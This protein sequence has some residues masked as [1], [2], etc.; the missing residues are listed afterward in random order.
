[1]RDLTY[2]IR[3]NN[4]LNMMHYLN[5]GEVSNFKCHQ[6]DIPGIITDIMCYNESLAKTCD[7]DFTDS[8]VG[9]Y[10]L[11]EVMTNKDMAEEICGQFSNKVPDK[12][13]IYNGRYGCKEATDHQVTSAKFRC[14]NVEI[15]SSYE[16]ISDEFAISDA[17]MNAFMTCSSFGCG[18][19]PAS[20]KNCAD[21]NGD[22]VDFTDF[23]WDDKS[24]SYGR[25][26]FC[27][28]RKFFDSRMFDMKDPSYYFNDDGEDYC[29]YDFFDGTTC[30][31]WDIAKMDGQVTSTESTESTT[32]TDTKPKTTTSTTTNAATESTESTESTTTTDTTTTATTTTITTTMSTTTATAT[33]DYGQTNFEIF[34]GLH[35][36]KN[37][38]LQENLIPKFDSMWFMVEKA[39]QLK[40]KT[41]ITTHDMNSGNSVVDT[42]CE[43][44]ETKKQEDH[45]QTILNCHSHCEAPTP[46]Y[47]DTYR[48]EISFWMNVD[49]SDMYIFRS[50]CLKRTL[51]QHDQIETNCQPNVITGSGC[52]TNSEAYKDADFDTITT[53]FSSLSADPSLI[54]NIMF[55]QSESNDIKFYVKGEEDNEC[56]KPTDSTPQDNYDTCIGATSEGTINDIDGTTLWEEYTTRVK[57]DPCTK[58]QEALSSINCYEVSN[59]EFNTCDISTTT[60]T[61]TTT[62]T[63]TTDS[64]T[65]ATTSTTTNNATTSTTTNTTTT[66]STTNATSTTTNTTT[67]DSTT[68]ADSKT[69]FS[70]KSAKS[71]GS[72]LIIGALAFVLF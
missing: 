17:L 15:H 34:N 48:D 42:Y 6:K 56:K 57:T 62:N 32:K 49:L 44:G 45:N 63:T 36:L 65:D 35:F 19:D 53:N 25:N 16:S 26:N 8:T 31:N 71:L 69:E 24:H 11:G 3:A 33:A 38:S 23:A 27:M 68:D 37:I 29:M 1:M 61:S 59:T 20:R 41:C 66:D 72:V 51:F 47:I 60:T 30:S 12:T 64:T 5:F 21:I 7:Y 39:I 13:C 55:G 58:I 18:V 43:F 22:D 28:L 9:D 4:I 70:T 14:T 46:H 50:P 40:I 52:V 54:C 2:L 67:T 10:F